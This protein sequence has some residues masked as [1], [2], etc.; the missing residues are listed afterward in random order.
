MTDDVRGEE[1]FAFVVLRPRC[2]PSLET[3]MR[4]T[5]PLPAG[6]RLLQGAG[7]CRFRAGLPQTASQKLA[8]AEIKALGSRAIASGQA[9]DLRHL[10]KRGAAFD[11]LAAT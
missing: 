2:R 1:V 5:E 11:A 9:F 6:A 4:T 8:R 3:A 10:K 7:L